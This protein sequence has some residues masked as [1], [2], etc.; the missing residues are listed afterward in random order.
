MR[1]SAV[2][3]CRLAEVQVR[4]PGESGQMCE[5]VPLD[6]SESKEDSLDFRERAEILQAGI[7]NVRAAE[8]KHP[9]G[10]PVLEMRQSRVGQRRARCVNLYDRLARTRCVRDNSAAQ[11]AK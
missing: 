4:E 10:R 3:D 6:F 5:P 7:A 8:I 9:D 11:F 1:Q 2:R